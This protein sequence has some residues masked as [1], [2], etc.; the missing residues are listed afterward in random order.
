M[1]NRRKVFLLC[2]TCVGLLVLLS[3]ARA[4]T[5]TQEQQRSNTRTVRVAVC[6]ILCIDSD[7]DGNFRRI[8]YALE[9]AA[10]QR[11]QLACFPETAILGWIN[12]QA[13]ELA[14][15]IPGKTTDRLAELAIQHGIMI[16]IG[17]CEK[18]GRN[19]YDAAVLI[20]ADGK[21]LAKHRK[22]NVLTE[23]MDPPYAPGNGDDIT[24]VETS[25]GRI[26]MLIC[27]DTF[28]DELVQRITAQSPDLL[29]VPYGWAAGRDEWPEHGKSLAAWV[30][31]TA[32]RAD[33]PVVGTDLVGVISSGPWRGK[34]YGGQSVVTNAD[35]VILGT[36]RDRD[37][38]VRTFEI[39]LPKDTL[40]DGKPV[41]EN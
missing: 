7:R 24:V 8:E 38:D 28:K 25:L 34:T 37:V 20:G 2:G 30:A 13:H 1:K 18:D 14:H 5:I 6:Q 15:P 40:R 29:L 33:C 26:G 22:T 12:S 9:E 16:C 23:L 11:A 3:F 17:L 41:R 19:L 21:L 35:G 27:A 36:L 39:P 32:Q 10:K 31:A 4:K